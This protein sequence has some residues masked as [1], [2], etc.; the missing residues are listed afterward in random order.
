MLKK[1]K[2]L[3]ATY[4]LYNSRMTAK[5]LFL[6][7]QR[8]PDATH[9]ME[10]M[11]RLTKDPDA[12]GVLCAVPSSGRNLKRHRRMVTWTTA[13]KD[14]GLQGAVRVPRRHRPRE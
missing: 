4:H 10:D 14:K 9:V 3:D 8:A 11:E 12:Q 6:A 13:V 7:L 2:D 5:G 1:L